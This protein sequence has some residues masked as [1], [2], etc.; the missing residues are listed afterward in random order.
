MLDE[1]IIDTEE[2]V[3]DEVVDEVVVDDEVDLDKYIPKETAL[4]W[5]RQ[6]KDAKKTIADYD[7]KAIEMEQV[8][9]IKAIRTKALERGMDDD[10]ADVLS[11]F[12]SELLKSLPK[13]DL[14]SQEVEDEIDDLKEIYPGIKSKKAELVETVKLYRK[15]NKGFSVEDAY[16][17]IGGKK[18]VRELKLEIEQSNAI[19]KDNIEPHPQ[20]GNPI[21]KSLLDEDERRILKEMQRNHPDRGWTEKKYND[22]IKRKR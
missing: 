12:A 13:T 11:E 19:G 15:A 9:R 6:L 4:V 14:I 21:K 3:V 10:T 20:S 5:K 2:E 1:Q 18:S 8:D 22:L 17:L 16:K 7:N